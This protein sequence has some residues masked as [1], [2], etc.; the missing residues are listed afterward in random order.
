MLCCYHCLLPEKESVAWSTYLTQ[1]ESGYVPGDM[2]W[3]RGR[4]SQGPNRT[5]T[6]PCVTLAQ[7]CFSALL[8]NAVT[9]LLVAAIAA[10]S[11]N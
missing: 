1:G 2:V 11:S 6:R 10:V 9:F 7:D 4:R 8:S 5:R 3:E